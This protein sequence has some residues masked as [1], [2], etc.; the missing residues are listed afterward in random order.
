MDTQGA[1]LVLGAGV[2]GQAAAKLLLGLGHCVTIVDAGS[3]SDSLVAQLRESGADVITGCRDLP[4]ADFS[5]CVASPGIALDSAWVQDMQGRGVAVIAELELGYRHCSVPL[6]AVTGTN[7]KSTL[8]KLL[9]GMFEQAGQRVAIAGN[10]GVPLC[11]VVQNQA[12]D[13][14]LIVVEV[15]SFQLELV[16]RFA[17][18]VGVVLN[19]QPDHLDRHGCMEE[20]RWLKSRMLQQ[21][22]SSGYCIIHLPELDKF[23][24]LADTGATWLSFG[25]SKSAD[26]VYDQDGWVRGLNA[27][28]GVSAD[29]R[30]SVF[31]NTVMGQTAAAA[32]AV[33]AVCGIDLP[34]VEQALQDYR[35]LPHR[36]EYVSELQGV[37][38][39]DDSKATNLAALEAA[40]EMLAGPVRLIAGGIL[41]EKSVD[42]VKEVLANK[43]RCVYL[44]GVA[45][46]TMKL[47][48]SDV[49]RC[50]LCGSLNAAVA[51][52]V[53]DAKAGDTV[54]LSP[55]CAS[56][57][58]FKSYRD[59]GEQFKRIVEEYD[60]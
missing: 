53:S 57:D 3:L 4:D 50:E 52:A 45:A 20:Y 28:A 25:D 17:P 35:G 6:V 14:D 51:S 42:F 59:R 16:D 23:R 8:V 32:L 47:G 34:Q 26:F 38:F 39:V 44:I 30:G 60:E 22:D 18:Q 27:F 1:V 5:L 37:R 24:A 36:M 56:F 31:E 54:L 9:A 10:Y 46:D 12:D 41:K 2:S 43:V 49:V 58:Q 11:D 33:A 19:L 21:I 48:W 40:L 7:G 13:L 15:S 55:G 29:V